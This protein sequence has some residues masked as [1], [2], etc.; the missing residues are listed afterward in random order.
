MHATA[1]EDPAEA[2]KRELVAAFHG[3]GALVDAALLSELAASPDGPVRA[4]AVLAGL[5]EVPFHFDAALWAALE[6]AHRDAAVPAP[7]PEPVVVHQAAAARKEAFAKAAA[8]IYDAPATG[9]EVPEEADPEPTDGEAMPGAVLVEAPVSAREEPKRL[10][11]QP[12]SDWQPLAAQHAGRLQVMQDMTGQSTCEGTTDDFRTYFRD[13]F[14]QLSKMLRMRRELRNAVPIERVKAGAQEVAVIGMVTETFET[15][16]GHRRISIE[17]ETGSTI[18]FVK[19]DDRPLLA[20]AQNLLPDEVIGVVGQVSGKGDVIWCNAILRPDIPIPQGGEKKGADVPLMAAFLSDIHVGSQ[21]F[22]SENWSAMLRWLRGGGSTK[23]ERDAAGRVK[24]VVI[25]GDLVDGVGIFPSQEHELSIGDIYEQ[26]GAFGDWMDHL[27][28]HVEVV[29]QPGN[30]DAVRPAEPQ[31]AFSKEVRTRFEHHDT[32]FVANPAMFRMHGVSTL[33]YHGFSLIDFARTCTDLEY[34]KPLDT[35]QRMLECRHLS[36]KYG[37]LTPVA[38]E[39][40]DYMV[41]SEVPDLFVTG[42]V[43]IPGLRNYRGVLNINCGTWQSQTGYQKKLNFVPDPAR[44][45]LVDLQSLRGTLVDF[46][47]PVSAGAMQ[48]QGAA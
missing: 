38:P 15:K 22:L 21:T 25:P 12:R 2:R 27:P 47:S 10:V 18:A 6:Q 37:D 5:K 28:D 29:V 20:M 36:P 30:H 33:G 35:M 48:A 13:R 8:S 42:H 45:P 4:Q 34:A 32:H 44:M 24:Y 46:Q 3:H 11:I 26:Y 39:H 43:H 41:I 9:D 19:A 14:K 17:D 40:H 16:N 7:A 31:P 23:R 1:V